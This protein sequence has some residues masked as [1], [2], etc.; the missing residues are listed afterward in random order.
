LLLPMPLFT[1]VI[2]IV[3]FMVSGSLT[4]ALETNSIAKLFPLFKFIE[5]LNPRR[6]RPN[7]PV[8]FPFWP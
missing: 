6:L 7:L 2:L 3:S 5:Q 8:S 4:K 1:R